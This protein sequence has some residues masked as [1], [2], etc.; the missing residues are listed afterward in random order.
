MGYQ[1]PKRMD[2]RQI[3]DF[4]KIKYNLAVNHKKVL[5]IMQKLGI[6]SMDLLFGTTGP[7]RIKVRV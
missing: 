4:L 1:S 5:G 7:N 3:K 2:Y 6:Q